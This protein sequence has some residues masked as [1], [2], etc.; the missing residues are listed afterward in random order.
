MNICNLDCGWHSERR[1]PRR[2][3]RWWEVKLENYVVI[4]QGIGSI[5]H[6]QYIAKRTGKNC[7]ELYAN[8]VHEG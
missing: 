7:V 4:S 6:F 5:I 2:M 1:F 8:E 3:L